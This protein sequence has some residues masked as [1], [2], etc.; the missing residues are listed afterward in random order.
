MAWKQ[1]ER[2]NATGNASPTECLKVVGEAITQ[3]QPQSGRVWDDVITLVEA[4]SKTLERETKRMQGSEHMMDALQLLAVIERIAQVVRESVGQYAD[5]L[6]AQR[7]LTRVSS[8]FSGLV[9][10]QP[11]QPSR[12]VKVID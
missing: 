2:A 4:R 1:Y 11:P 5:K 8:E 6:T 10:Q 12:P 9:T 7:I 3:A